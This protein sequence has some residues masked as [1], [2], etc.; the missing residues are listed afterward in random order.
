MVSSIGLFGEALLEVHVVGRM[1]YVTEPPLEQ[2][3]V[4][5]HVLSQQPLF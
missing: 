2:S 3:F 1:G 4:I 5:C